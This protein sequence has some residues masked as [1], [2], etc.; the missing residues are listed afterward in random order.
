MQ[1]WV[2]MTLLAACAG[3]GIAAALAVALHLPPSDAEPPASDLLQP[4]AVKPAKS[5][6][7]IPPAIA[8]PDPLPP[9]ALVPASPPLALAPHHN[10]LVRQ[11]SYL[12]DSIDQLQQSSHRRERSLLQAIESLQTQVEDTRAKVRTVSEQAAQPAPQPV[13]PPAPSPASQPLPPPAPEPLPLAESAALAPVPPLAALAPAEARNEV[14]R[15]SG[16]EGLSINIQNTDI[17]TVLETISRETGL[18][19]IASKNVTG[20]VSANLTGVDIETALAAILKTTG[21]VAAREG[22]IVFIGA[23]ADLAQMNQI[24][25]RIVTRVYRPNYTKAADLQVLFTPLLS[26]E[27]KLTVS[28]PSQVGMPADQTKTG[29]NDLAVT[30]A[31]IVRDYEAVLLQL[32]EI[33]ADIDTM[34][35]QVAIEAMILSVKL[36]DTFKFGV[37]FAALR[38]EANASLISGAPKASLGNISLTDGGLH[39]GFLDGSL[40]TFIDALEKVGDTNVIASPRLT[41]L[42][43]QR[44]EIQIGEELGY[45]STTVTPTS[46]TQ[47]VNFLDVGT[48]LRIRPFIGNDGLVRLEVH[49][50]L[51]TGSVQLQGTASLPQKAVTQVTTNVLC[52]DGR[53]VVIGG[54]I[55]EDLTTS[56]SQLP[57]VG[58]LPYVGWLFRQK[59]QTIDRNEIIVLITPRIVSEPFMSQEGEKLGN[60]MTE[61]QRVYFDKMSPLGKRHLGEHHVR[62]ARAAYAAGD[63]DTAIKQ[64]DRA[65]HYD[66]QSG[67]AVN[68]R[69]EIVA[70][71]GF[72]DESIHEYLHHGLAPL[73]GGHKHYSRQG[74]PWK[75]ADEFGPP[76]PAGIDDRG[77]AGPLRTILR[78]SPVP[79]NPFDPSAPPPL[80]IKPATEARPP[81]GPPAPVV[82][83]EPAAAPQ[84]RGEAR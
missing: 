72:E 52:P 29:G 34:P 26:P 58:N 10:P 7:Q 71:G 57:V 6:P 12:E 22:D 82:I 40:G 81:A 47:T 35:R 13:P 33:F 49:P 51:S 67:D 30:D 41:C 54:L 65:I 5:Q 84:L 8:T 36:S 66:P 75:D 39:F 3:C 18:N 76:Q 21:Y 53:T 63:M 50:E 78:P 32:D 28:T 80:R 25:D 79:H 46:S 69:R 43:K 31:V 9:P 74:Y 73:T 68:L 17:R 44:A 55:R 56:T 37:N 62:A 19:I 59:S 60:Q 11:I 14:R 16:D 64:V 83:P 1:I 20:P 48:L 2:R 4:T 27:G 24:Q 15:G 77:T 38:N 23:P 42:N 61:R 45:I 70:A